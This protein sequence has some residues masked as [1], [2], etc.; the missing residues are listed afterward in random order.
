MTELLIRTAIVRRQG[1]GYIYAGDPKK[2][3]AG[4]PHTIILKYK[5]GAT[6]RG[7][8]NYNAHAV[9]AISKPEP[10]LVDVSGAGY[11]TI[12]SASGVKCS[13]ID[14]GIQGFRSVAEV[15]GY[16]YAVGLR[17]VVY[18]LD[19]PGQWTALRNNLPETFDGQ[20][21][22]GSD[23]NDVYAVGR[24][25][26]VWHFDGTQWLQEAVPSSVTLTCVIC[27][28]NDVV[29]AGGH[30][31]VLLEKKAGSWHIIETKIDDH[32]WDLA[33]FNNQLYVSTMKHVYHLENNAMSIV[34]FGEDVPKS[35][36]QLSTAAG[37]MWS[38]GESDIMLFDGTQWTR[39]L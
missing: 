11:Y 3:A 13:S 35:C 33:W 26:Q 4:I 7:E 22:H 5:D 17:G 8:N 24:D 37:V 20:A 9:C 21:I 15:G 27:D 23:I 19:K 39:I 12:N 32:I 16:A 14:K 10:G 34:D 38:S 1:L 18:R 2:E 29:Y 36:Y 6:E 28:T 25:G 31:G 30:Q